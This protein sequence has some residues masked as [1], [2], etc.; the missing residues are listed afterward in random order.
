MKARK[1][2]RQRSD[3]DGGILYLIAA[4][5]GNLRDITLRA[6]DALRDAP[7]IA[8][9]DTRVCRRLLAA[10]GITGKRL[11]SLRAHNENAAAEKLLAVIH[12]A[13]AAAYVSDAGV[14]GICDPGARL[15]RRAREA[16]VAVSP[17]PG[18]SALTAAL[19]AAGVENE[20]LFIGFPP[21]TSA[22]RRRVLER[23]AE[24]AGGGALVFF[25]APHRIAAALA[26]AR[27]VFGNEARAVV[28][29]EM[30]KK[31]EQIVEETLD[32]I[33][34][35]LESG[36]LPARGEFTIVAHPPPRARADAAA[37]SIFNAL[38]RHLPPRRAAAIAAE[39]CG[40]AASGL[41]RRRL[42]KKNDGAP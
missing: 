20:V 4:P 36:A 13:G 19:S 32:A 34:T 35:M 28:C 15:V 7:V 11:L 42:E 40:V 1:H 41:Y 33:L 38:C 22:R 31:H 23:A 29:R 5:I 9:E 26:D 24:A 30:S 16:G 25:E 18:A 10:H 8:C 17:L 14:A 39:A 21:A 27:H 37:D 3:G 12:S 2:S 6:L